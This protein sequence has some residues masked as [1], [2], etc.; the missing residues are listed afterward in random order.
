MRGAA[1]T[2]WP[3]SA[4]P[5]DGRGVGYP[6]TLARP[7]LEIERVPRLRTLK[8]RLA[9]QQQRL[10]SPEKRAD[11]FY[12]SPEW[13]ALKA[14]R[15]LDRDYFAAKARA[16]A[17]EWVILDHKRERKDGGDELDPANTEWLTVSEHAAKTARAR[18]DRAQGR[19]GG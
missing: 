14:R 6:F 16:K 17:G 4:G 8:D 19:G 13:R 1:L 15:R 18:S 3:C 11:R 2:A 12:L 5:R 10:R 7:A 9:R